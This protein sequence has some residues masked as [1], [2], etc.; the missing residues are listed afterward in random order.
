MNL[1]CSS[2]VEMFHELLRVYSFFVFFFIFLYFS[3]DNNGKME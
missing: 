2:Y 1:V 3:K